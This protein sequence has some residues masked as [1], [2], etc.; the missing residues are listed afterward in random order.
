MEIKCIQPV[1]VCGV[2][3]RTS[4]QTIMQYVGDMPEKLM[5]EI[6]SQGINPVC[7]QIWKYTGCDGNPET[8]FDLM[9]CIPV[10]KQGE[11]RNGFEFLTLET[12]TCA[13]HLH[14]GSWSEIAAAY[15]QL[16]G[17]ITANGSKITGASREVYLNCDFEDPS[18][19]LTEI[20]LE[21]Q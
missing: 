20:Q 1:L 3:V 7:S 21:I 6:A 5:N 18:S 2:K 10:D 11:D 16:M 19:C 15:C 9:I 8:V 13:T 12:F 14:K 17:E 4:L